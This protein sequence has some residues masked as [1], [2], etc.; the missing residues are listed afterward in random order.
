MAECIECLDGL[1]VEDIIRKV[2]D[3][4][5]NGNVSWRLWVVEYAEDCVDCTQYMSPE[6]FLRKSLYCNNGI[7]YIKVTLD[8]LR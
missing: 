3:C 6:D 7:W 2:V 8:M 1:S 4:D 5:G